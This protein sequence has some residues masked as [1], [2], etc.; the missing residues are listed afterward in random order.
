MSARIAPDLFIFVPLVPSPHSHK[1][2]HTSQAVSPGRFFCSLFGSGIEGKGGRRILLPPM[3]YE[4]PTCAVQFQK[5]IFSF[6]DDRDTSCRSHI[7][8]R[9]GP[10]PIPAVDFQ[11]MGNRCFV[12][13]GKSSAHGYLVR[14]GSAEAVSADDRKQ[15]AGSL[16]EG[17]PAL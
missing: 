1:A 14:L 4:P 17:R 5:I 16:G 9:F 11:D 6:D 3:G 12:W 8:A 2:A 13:K 10:V 15:E 7:V